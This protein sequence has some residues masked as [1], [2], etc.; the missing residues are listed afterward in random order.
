MIGTNINLQTLA[1]AKEFS[2]DISSTGSINGHGKVDPDGNVEIRGIP[3]Q[4]LDLINV[5]K[6]QK[7]NTWSPLPPDGP[8]AAITS[9][10]DYRP[11]PIA[12]LGAEDQVKKDASHP[13]RLRR[14]HAGGCW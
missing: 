1:C 11:S 13:G 9:T 14:L 6:V 12:A 7:I 10:R 8:G 2:M 5:G 3:E 4:Q